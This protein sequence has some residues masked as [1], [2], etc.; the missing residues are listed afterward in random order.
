MSPLSGA[1]KVKKNTAFQNLLLKK[2]QY[3]SL[4]IDNETE[5]SV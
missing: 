1:S 2:S 4:D 3:A 5:E